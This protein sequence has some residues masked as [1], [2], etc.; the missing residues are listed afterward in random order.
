MYFNTSYANYLTT[1]D[2]IFDTRLALMNIMFPNFVDRIIELDLYTDRFKDVFTVDDVRIGYETFLPFYNNRKKS[3]IKYS[4]LTFI[5]YIISCEV[6][7]HQHN[8]FNGECFRPWHIHIN[9]YPYELDGKEKDSICEIF[10]Q[11]MESKPEIIFHRIDPKLIGIDF[12]KNNEIEVVIDY[13]GLEWLSHIMYESDFKFIDRKISLCVPKIMN[14]S[15][16]TEEQIN[17]EFFKTLEVT[18]DSHIEL[19]FLDS[20][21]FSDRLLQIKKNIDTSTEE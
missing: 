8:S 6:N 4:G 14:S 19:S 17:D 1:L 13:Y 5:P 9:T 3:L 16:L 2:T 7:R 20:Y 11:Y 21:A 12:L 10:H 18:F 15:G